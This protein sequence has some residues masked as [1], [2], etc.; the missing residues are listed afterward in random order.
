[1]SLPPYISSRKLQKI[2][3]DPNQATNGNHMLHETDINNMTTVN[4]KHS[5]AIISKPA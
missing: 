1:V 2:I 5:Q 3:I 4:L